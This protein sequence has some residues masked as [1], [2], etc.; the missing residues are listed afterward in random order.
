MDA[1]ETEN[2]GTGAETLPAIAVSN[3]PARFTPQLAIEICERLANGESLRRI[4]D[5]DERFPTESAVRQW[6]IRD[7]QGFA[8]QYTHAREIGL[9]RMADELI[10][11]ADDSSRDTTTRIDGSECADTEWINRSRLRV[12][13]RKW[14]LSK[15]APKKYGDHQSIELTG[16]DGAPIASTTVIAL[17]Q[18]MSPEQ[19]L[20][21][22]DRLQ[23]ASAPVIEAEPISEQGCGDH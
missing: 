14:Y 10:E 6:V 3:G 13:A 11:I 16:K 15:L 8:A 20:A 9:D 7:V 23:I 1:M 4:C 12:D 21:A 5:S 18:S 2:L 22:R 19:L 17:A